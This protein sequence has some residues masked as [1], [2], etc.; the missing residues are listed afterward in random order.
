MVFDRMGLLKQI[1]MQPSDS[2]CYPYDPR[3]EKHFRVP[4]GSAYEHDNFGRLIES[5]WVNQNL[6]NEE[7]FTTSH[8]QRKYDQHGHQVEYA[9]QI[10]TLRLHEDEVRYWNETVQS[11]TTYTISYRGIADCAGL[12]DSDGDKVPDIIDGS[13]DDPK[14]YEKF[15]P[16]ACGA[17][18][19]VKSKSSKYVPLE[20]GN[21]TISHRVCSG[22][23]I[24]QNWL[25]ERQ[26]QI[27]EGQ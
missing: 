3:T 15:D 8:I 18:E 12:K 11:P 13:P 16:R 6:L 14:G 2:A 21:F 23:A 22:S 20:A 4:C 25:A 10:S 24:Y 5:S 26:Q 7:E 27:D 1:H 17:P 19:P 9:I